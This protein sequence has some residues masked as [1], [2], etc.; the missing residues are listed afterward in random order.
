MS[1][2]KTGPNYPMESPLGHLGWCL[3]LQTSTRPLR[4]YRER[5][6]VE[7]T[8]CKETRH[9]QSSRELIWNPLLNRTIPGITIRKIPKKPLD[10]CLPKLETYPATECQKCR[11]RHCKRFMQQI[12]IQ[13]QPPWIQV[14]EAFSPGSPSFMVHLF[15][16]FLIRDC[17]MGLL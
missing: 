12:D 7:L 9:E 11:I 16:D 15:F 8:I 10:I 1:W 13:N 5:L 4:K 2:W 6:E 17:S 3:T 14:C